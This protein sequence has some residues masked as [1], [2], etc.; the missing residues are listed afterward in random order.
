MSQ[1]DLQTVVSALP[2]AAAGSLP[3]A[4]PL[5]TLLVRALA[6]SAALACSRGATTSL[7]SGPP[8]SL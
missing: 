6:L 8:L 5:T 4:K 7:A 1:G 3:V 2:A